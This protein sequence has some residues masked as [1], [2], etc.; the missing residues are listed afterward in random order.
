LA[1]RFAVASLKIS[2]EHNGIRLTVTKI[3]ADRRLVTAITN[4]VSDGLGNYVVDHDGDVIDIE[5]LE[6]V[7]IKTFS[8]GGEGFGGERHQSSGG[9]DVV[10]HHTFCTKTWGSLGDNLRLTFPHVPDLSHM[11]ELGVVTF[12]VSDDAL[13]TQVKGGNLPEVSIEGDGYRREIGA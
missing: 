12:F 6:D 7:F 8:K 9:A 2:G 13:W 5:N 1:K 11:P 3:D 4:V 10:M